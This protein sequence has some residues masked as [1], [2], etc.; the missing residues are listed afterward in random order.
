MKRSLTFIII[1]MAALLTNAQDLYIGSFFVTTPEQE[2]LLG[3]GKDKWTTRRQTVYDM[4][5]YELPDV[6]GLQ[7]ATSSQ[8]TAMRAGMNSGMSGLASYKLAGDILYNNTVE[9]DTCGVVD[10]MPEGCSCTWA[11]MRKDGTEFYVYNICFTADSAY[12]S[13]NRLRTVSAEMVPTTTPCFV[14][15][16]L[17]MKE[18]TQPHKRMTAKFPDCFDSAT[19]KSAEYGTVNNF[20]LENNHSTDRFDFVFASKNVTVSAY[21]QLQYAYFTSE[22]GTYKRRLPSSHFPVMAKVKM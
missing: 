3:D 10:G 9:L 18:G 5:K 1:A 17:G 16:N 8:M 7:S 4:F 15:G 22:N 2:A 19:Y 6:L 12:V 20:D 14:V 21:G 11:K 13:T